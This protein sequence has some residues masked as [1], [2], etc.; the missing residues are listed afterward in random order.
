M[1]QKNNQAS[2][3]QQQVSQQLETPASAPKMNNFIVQS[4]QPQDAIDDFENLEENESEKDFEDELDDD[5]GIPNE[6]TDRVPQLNGSSLDLPPHL[7]SYNFR[8][9][10]NRKNEN[11]SRNVE[12][13]Y[14]SAQQADCLPQNRVDSERGGPETWGSRLL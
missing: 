4:I 9:A 7:N 13:S 3:K 14:I 1:R 8:P 6:M 12:A 5:E 2:T 10:M 11:N